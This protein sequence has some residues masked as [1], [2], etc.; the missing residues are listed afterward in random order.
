[1][2]NKKKRYLNPR[3]TQ[4]VITIRTRFLMGTGC[5]LQSRTVSSEFLF[6]WTCWSTRST[7]VASLCL[8]RHLRRAF[9]FCRPRWRIERYRP[10]DIRSFPR[11][12]RFDPSSSSASSPA[13][14]KMHWMLRHLQF[15]P[16]SP[17]PAQRGRNRPRQGHV[18]LEEL[19]HQSACALQRFRLVQRATRDR[20]RLVG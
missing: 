20:S 14:A 9:R 11:P 16:A 18:G 13:R 3:N 12:H 6:K 7:Q 4:T 15:Q 8:P 17:A 1:M 2:P 10:F 19:V 5:S